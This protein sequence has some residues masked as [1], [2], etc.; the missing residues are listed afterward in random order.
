MADRG[1]RPDL[2]SE[3]FNVAA[4]RSA[5]I[6]TDRGAFKAGEAVPS[7]RKGSGA[8]GGL[9]PAAAANYNRPMSIRAE[10]TPAARKARNS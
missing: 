2:F 5:Q 8:G 3:L 7:S 10:R 4:S 1:S 6:T 9:S